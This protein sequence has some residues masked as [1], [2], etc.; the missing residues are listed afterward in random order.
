MASSHDPCDFKLKLGHASMC[1]H[2]WGLAWPPGPRISYRGSDNSKSDEYYSSDSGCR[3][4]CSLIGD[5]SVLSSSCLNQWPEWSSWSSHIR[6][7]TSTI[8]SLCTRQTLKFLIHSSL[9]MRSWR[10]GKSPLLW[11]MLACPSLS[12]KSQGSRLDAISGHVRGWGEL[13]AYY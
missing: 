5:S 10:S 13:S 6:W 1:H 3:N 11:H 2:S 4:A 9:C 8:S 12:L 7:H